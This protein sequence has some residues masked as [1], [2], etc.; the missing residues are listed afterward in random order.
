MT[1]TLTFWSALTSTI[2]RSFWSVVVSRLLLF[3]LLSLAGDVFLL[4]RLLLFTLTAS[5]AP[6]FAAPISSGVASISPWRI[7]GVET[8]APPNWGPKFSIVT[9][10]PP[11]W[12]PIFAIASSGG[13]DGFAWAKNDGGAMGFKGDGAG[14]NCGSSGIA[15]I[16]PM[17]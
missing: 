7:E 5:A 4:L 15:G 3:S 1:S 8:G 6:E 17:S 2:T 16:R 13:N 14:G 10:A 12:D 9:G 11:N